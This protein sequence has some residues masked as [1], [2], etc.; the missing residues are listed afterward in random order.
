MRKSIWIL[1]AVLWFTCPHAA[2]Y[3]DAGTALQSVGISDAIQ[4]LPGQ[5]ASLLDGVDLLHAA[6]DLGGSIG[7]LLEQIDGR[8]FFLSAARSLT[9]MLFIAVIIGALSGFHSI[10]GTSEIPVVAVAGALGMTG[11]LFRD[12]QGMLA[13]CTQTMEQT[14]VFST[15]LL[16]VMA[17]AITLSGAPATASVTQGVT[18]FALNLLIRFITSVLVPA[19][20]AYIAIITI[21]AALGNDIL[22]G[23][24][25]FIKWLTTGS[26]KL[27]LTVFIAYL[28]IS[29]AIGGSIDA[30]TL[31]T[32]KFA[33]SGSVPVVGGIISDA[34][35]SMLAGL[36]TIKNTVGI[37]G[38][39]GVAAICIVPFLQVGI[40]YLF[41]KAGSAVLSPICSPSLSKLMAGL[42]DSFGLMLGML[43]TCSAIL[44]FELVFSILMVKPI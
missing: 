26:L 2:A 27:M 7:Q 13:L 41:F 42:G 31:K 17:G 14:S 43:G 21:N 19:V 16:P 3:D 44:F 29:G 1:L 15:A 37:F 39:L 32:A 36:V 6:D 22:S 8:A 34:T 40:N 10:A 4:A 5:A 23:L 30:V 11:V 38:M 20:C 18:L 35:E 9:K 24:A 25:N 28:S 33:V 12:L